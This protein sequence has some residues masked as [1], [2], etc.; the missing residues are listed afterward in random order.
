[1]PASWWAA[2]AW[3]PTTASPRPTSPTRWS[4]FAASRRSQPVWRGSGVGEGTM[5]Y[6]QIL[7]ET[8]G[9]VG[10]IRLNRP[11]KL[12]AWTARMQDELCDQIERWN[13][14]PGIGAI[15]LTG[16]GRAFCAGADLGGF[17]QRLE[18]IQSGP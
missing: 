6:E 14:D 1:M 18:R 17:G 10:I 12:N 8:R 15:V 5:A 16:Q 13:D 9:R 2:T 4:A 7:T 11:E 3:S